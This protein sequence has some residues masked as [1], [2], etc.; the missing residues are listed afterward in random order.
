MIMISPTTQKKIS[1]HS[2]A[3]CV[4]S[5]FGIQASV[6]GIASIQA[7][8]PYEWSVADIIDTLAELE[9]S[10]KEIAV[11]DI[12]LR[13]KLPTSQVLYLITCAEFAYVVQFDLQ[14]NENVITP[15][16]GCPN[17]TMYGLIKLVKKNIWDVALFEC[18]IKTE[19]K[20]SLLP[21]LDTHWFWSGI[22]SN[23]NNYIKS[24]LAVLLTNVF[25]LGTSMF[26]MVVYN[27]IIPANAIESL[28]ALVFG[29]GLLLAV[30]FM[31]RQIGGNFCLL[32]LIMQTIQYPINCLSR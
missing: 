4:L 1:S 5:N 32:L 12:L 14:L 21:A 13:R 20:S 28:Y 31:T 24:G 30:D 27:R 19:P 16:D 11:K 9:I 6:A 3:T 17:V 2:I 10:A 22:L 18:S 23:S 25:A 29:M 15:V 26:S 8:N 7:S